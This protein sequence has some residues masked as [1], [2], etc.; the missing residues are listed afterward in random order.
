MPEWC[1]ERGWG[2]VSGFREMTVNGRGRWRRE[3]VAF[4]QNAWEFGVLEG[5]GRAATSC[6]IL[7]ESVKKRGGVLRSLV[8]A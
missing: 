7:Q 1:R 6:R 3:A 8:E 5:R 4:C 2:N